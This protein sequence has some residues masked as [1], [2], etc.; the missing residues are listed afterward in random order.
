MRRGDMYFDLSSH[1]LYIWG[2]GGNAMFDFTPSKIKMLNLRHYSKLDAHFSLE[3]R[4]LCKLHKINSANHKLSS[5]SNAVMI[6]SRKYVW[7]IK[8]YEKD[9]F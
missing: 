4:E 7:S 3:I 1:F 9:L 5:C 8:T 2:D 6:V